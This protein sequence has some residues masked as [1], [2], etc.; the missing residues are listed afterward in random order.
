MIYTPKEAEYNA[1]YAAY[2]VA[3]E[4]FYAGTISAEVFIGLRVAMQKAADEWEAE[5]DA[6]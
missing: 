1:A 6:S 5:R 3:R 2:V 4:E